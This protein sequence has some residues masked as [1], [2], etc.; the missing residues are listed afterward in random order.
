MILPI[1]DV[2]VGESVPGTKTISHRQNEDLLASTRA[3]CVDLLLLHPGD[4]LGRNVALLDEGVAGSEAHPTPSHRQVKS[5]FLVQAL[6][7]LT[8]NAHPTSASRTDQ[9]LDPPRFMMIRLVTFEA[10][11]V[12]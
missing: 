11:P 6:S 4:D 7:V 2:I 10:A 8:K 12:Q 3:D 1:D 5:P 9:Q